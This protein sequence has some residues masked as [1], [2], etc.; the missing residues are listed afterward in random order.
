M[1]VDLIKTNLHVPTVALSLILQN[2]FVN[3]LGNRKL[4]ASLQYYTS[5]VLPKIAVAICNYKMETEPKVPKQ[6]AHSWHELITE[7]P[8]ILQKKKELVLCVVYRYQRQSSVFIL[9][10]NCQHQIRTP[11]KFLKPLKLR[12]EC[13]V[14][15]VLY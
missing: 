13:L 8:G 9:S 7:E 14:I 5:V 4:Y 15:Q 11:V 1:S 2:K 6:A 10:S 3:F 12:A